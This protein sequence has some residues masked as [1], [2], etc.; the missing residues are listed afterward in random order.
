MKKIIGTMGLFTV[1]ALFAFALLSGPLS[2]TKAVNKDDGWHRSA[3]EQAVRIA[4][5][6]GP[7]RRITYAGEFIEKNAGEYVCDSIG[8]YYR[9]F[10]M[11]DSMQ[12][13][14]SLTYQQRR[15]ML[16][17]LEENPCP[18][19]L[20]FERRDWMRRFQKRNVTIEDQVA[21]HNAYI[22][23]KN[24]YNAAVSIPVCVITYDIRYKGRKGIY[25]ANF[26]SP[27]DSAKLRLVNMERLTVYNVQNI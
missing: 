17:H 2:G 20:E 1:L 10:K 11:L 27:I 19:W 4:S 21:L 16:R 12:S 26:I 15:T 22:E 3:A 24:K 23:A 14:P 6:D 7:V 13:F 18:T 5:K 9:Y 25:R 8:E